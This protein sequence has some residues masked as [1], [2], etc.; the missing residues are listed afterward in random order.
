M[1]DTAPLR[2][3]T[4]SVT[5]ETQKFAA[6]AISALLPDLDKRRL[7]KNLRLMRGAY[8]NGCR[9]CRSHVEGYPKVTSTFFLSSVFTKHPNARRV[10]GGPVPFGGGGSK[11]APRS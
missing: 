1:A 3:R 7:S 8:T 9:C 11:L 10:G 4:T 5:G 2:K 6:R